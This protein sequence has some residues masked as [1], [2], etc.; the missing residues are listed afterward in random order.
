VDV[1]AQARIFAS[2]ALV[3]LTL[4]MRWGRSHAIEAP[5]VANHA[6]SSSYPAARMRL[7]LIDEDRPCDLVT[8]R[9]SIQGISV[10]CTATASAA[11]A[12][13]RLSRSTSPSR[14]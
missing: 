7:L 2:T 5:R 9:L 3:V 10:T 14:A 13:L 12:E 6:S 11:L 8:R 1:F 4:A